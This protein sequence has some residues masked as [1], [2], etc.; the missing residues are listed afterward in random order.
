MGV[1]TILF[2]T[3]SRDFRKNL[4]DNEQIKGVITLK[5]GVF[6]Y[7]AAAGTVIVL[8]GDD[9]KTWF[10]STADL[11]SLVSLLAGNLNNAF[12]V[13]YSSVVLPDNMLPE[14]YNGDDR[15]IEDNFEEAQSKP[16]CEVAEIIGGKSARR[17]DLAKEGIPYLRARD[18][19]NGLIVTPDLF[20]KKEEADCFAKQFI[21]EGDIL[22][23]KHFGQ[24]KITFVRSSDVPAI[25]SDALIIIRPFDVSES[26]LYNYLTSKTGNEIFN[27]QLNRIQKGSIVPSITLSDLRKI[28]IPVFTQEVMQK[29]EKIDLLS[30]EDVMDT[31]QNLLKHANNETNTVMDVMNALIAAG[32]DEQRFQTE[33]SARVSLKEGEVW[34]ADLLYTLPDGRKVI[35]E[36]KTDIM[37]VDSKLIAAMKIILS[38]ESNYF[39]VLT[40]GIY[41]ETHRSGVKQSLK[42]IVA[43]TI[44]QIENLGKEMC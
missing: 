34:L 13:Y 29:L 15:L 40:N 21:Q 5:Q 20:V 3:S 27:R 37:G 8:G 26:Y 17:Y 7:T 41:Y 42:T 22:L 23:S 1:A 12:P 6:E 36:V 28:E 4:I 24:N 39:F 30:K 25:V 9:E 16:L 19:Q 32:W 14:F 2:G 38:E 18:I 44:T 31:I 11:Q 43:P 35:I 33:Q 10:T